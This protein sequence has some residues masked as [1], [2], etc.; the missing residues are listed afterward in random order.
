[1]SN[2]ILFFIDIIFGYGGPC[3]TRS[4]PGTKFR[5]PNLSFKPLMV[6]AVLTSFLLSGCGA[7]P[8]KK[9]NVMTAPVFFEI[10]S[11]NNVAVEPRSKVVAEALRGLESYFVDELGRSTAAEMVSERYERDFLPKPLDAKQRVEMALR[12][13]FENCR[14]YMRFRPHEQP[15]VHLTSF[16][17]NWNGNAGSA[18]AIVSSTLNTPQ[19]TRQGTTKIMLDLSVESSGEIITVKISNL[20]YVINCKFGDNITCLFTSDVAVDDNALWGKL[21]A[22]KFTPDKVPTIESVRQRVQTALYSRFSAKSGKITFDEKIEKTY[23]IDYATAKARL[24]RA[25]GA[26]KYDPERNAFVLEKTYENPIKANFGSVR[27]EYVIALF[28]ERNRTFASISGEYGAF[29]DKF[30]GPDKFGRETF[31]DALR[32]YETM[33]DRLLSK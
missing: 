26:F 14:S 3:M 24:Q 16:S 20:A 6:I 18:T 29:S 10:P 25:M 13:V 27:H 11:K 8:V 32:G 1:M 7:F 28:P 15:S 4:A 5:S 12:E 31:E 23:R 2:Y 22:A 19:W 30:G 21:R 9:N 17:I 33:V